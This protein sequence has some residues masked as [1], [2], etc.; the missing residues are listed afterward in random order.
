MSNSNSSA[1]TPSSPAA[2]SPGVTPSPTQQQQPSWESW[3]EHFD[4]QDQSGTK[5]DFL[6][7]QLATAIS[8]EDYQAA[9]AIKSEISSLTSAD[10][11]AAIQQRLAAALAAEQYAEAAVLRDQGWALLEGWWACETTDAAGHLLKVSPE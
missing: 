2:A 5:L 1:S 4:Q 7:P 3:C 8:D 11:V 6:Q 10:A 9:A